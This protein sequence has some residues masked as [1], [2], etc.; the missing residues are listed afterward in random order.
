MEK[1]NNTDQSD[2]HENDIPNLISLKLF[3]FES[4]TNIRDI[5]SSQKQPSEV[6][7]KK[8]VLRNFAKF[9]GKHLYK[10]LFFNKVAGLYPA[11]LLKKR[12]IQ[13]LSCEFC[14]ISKNNFFYRTPPVA[15][16]LHP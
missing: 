14:E 1:E 3:E 9:N 4:K 13:V 10:S 2:F 12:L 16:S 15:V 8:V 11:T 5:K 7:Y 6:F